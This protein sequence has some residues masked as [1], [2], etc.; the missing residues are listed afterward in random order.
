VLSGLH[1][2]TAGAYP[3]GTFVRCWEEPRSHVGV[4]GNQ[5]GVSRWL[6]LRQ[7]GHVPQ[8]KLALVF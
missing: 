6:P 7:V 8:A 3:W 5:S 2:A 4:D 1:P